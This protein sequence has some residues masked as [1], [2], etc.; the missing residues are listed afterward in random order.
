M[1]RKGKC[2]K[3][4]ENSGNATKYATPANQF[5]QKS[6]MDRHKPIQHQCN[7][8]SWAA[9]AF[10]IKFI[11]WAESEKAKT[12]EI[13]SK[14][15][16]WDYKTSRLLI[17]FWT[18]GQHSSPISICHTCDE[19]SLI[20]KHE[21]ISLETMCC[22]SMCVTHKFIQLILSLD[23]EGKLTPVGGQIRYFCSSVFDF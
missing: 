2:R 13:V 15:I 6:K 5:K 1:V 14:M 16:W 17:V 9:R 8:W 7:T 21:E 11:T 22:P 18:F 12:F 23:N 19:L 10:R 20:V 4:T 3:R